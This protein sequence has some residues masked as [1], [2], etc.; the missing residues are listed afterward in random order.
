[1]IFF[2]L[3]A[4]VTSTFLNTAL[5]YFFKKPA[6]GSFKSSIKTFNPASLSFYT[7][8]IPMPPEAPETMADFPLKVSFMSIKYIP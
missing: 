6:G 2:S 7:H 8:S 3:A 4:F 5:L 1:M